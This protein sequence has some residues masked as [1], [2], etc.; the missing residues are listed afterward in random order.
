MNILI[1]DDHEILKEGLI[2]RINKIIPNANCLFTTSI[3]NTIAKINQTKIDLIISDLEFDLDSDLDGFY[4]IKNIKQLEPN[5]K[6]IALSTHNSYSILKKVQA[7]GFNSYIN[8]AA[9]DKE[10]SDTLQNVIAQDS[11]TIY[12]SE[13]MKRLIKKKNI[14]YSNIFAESLYGLNSLSPRELELVRLTAKTTDRHQLAK[15]M[16]IKAYT[17]DT[18]FKK[19][20][21]KLNLKHR[22]ELALF[23]EEFKSK[24]EKFINQ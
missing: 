4:L 22:K 19:A 9:T 24:I 14:F 3:R 13:T 7:S 5:I 18:H 15:M 2:K 20:L 23:S 10:F 11:N 12:E 17:V 21:Y 6:A 8:K 1:I 16:N